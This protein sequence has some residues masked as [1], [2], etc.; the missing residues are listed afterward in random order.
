MPD[1][2]NIK[3]C[4]VFCTDE[5]LKAIKREYSLPLIWLGNHPPRDP[6]ELVHQFALQN[7]LPEIQGFYGI[8]LANREFITA[9][10]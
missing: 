8:D 5:Q 6:Q 1:P 4:N 2:V 9:R 10:H 3:R 7:G